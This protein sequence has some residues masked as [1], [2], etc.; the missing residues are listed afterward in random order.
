MN[1]ESENMYG[2]LSYAMVGGGE[3]S[4]I[5]P[6]HRAAIR[7]TKD[8]DFPQAREGRR[9]IQFVDAALASN[10]NDAQWAVLAEL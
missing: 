1:T 7:G 2:R 4:F 6:V 3:G 8:R 10:R 9:S 5:G